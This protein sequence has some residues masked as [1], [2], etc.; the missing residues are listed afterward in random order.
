[1][2]YVVRAVKTGEI[3]FETN[4]RED[5]DTYLEQVRKVGG[6]VCVYTLDPAL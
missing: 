4:E 2:Y 3:V 5:L 1:M 6:K